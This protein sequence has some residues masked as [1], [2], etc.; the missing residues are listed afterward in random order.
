MN[1]LSRIVLLSET[2]GDFDDGKNLLRDNCVTDFPFCTM[3][4]GV[5]LNKVRRDSHAMRIVVLWAVVHGKSHFERLCLW[6]KPGILAKL[7]FHW[8]V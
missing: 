5:P 4:T 3:D 7:P 1:T 2:S 6:T 8:I